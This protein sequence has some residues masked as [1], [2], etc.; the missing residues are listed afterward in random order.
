MSLPTIP[1]IT[2]KIS[3]NQCDTINLLLSAIALEEIG[4]S[5]ILNAEAE[6]LQTFLNTCPERIEDYLEINQSINQLLRTIVNSQILIQFKLEEVISLNHDCDCCCE[7]CHHEEKNNCS[8]KKHHHEGK[9]DC[10][11][12]CHHEKNDCRCKKCH[13]EDKND[14][15]CKKCHHDEST[16]SYCKKCYSSPLNRCTCKNN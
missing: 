10:Y 2:P 6:K 9:C 14:C 16:D 5:N 3:L 8:C 13:R 1:N 12:K 11:K 7:K 4:F 15:H